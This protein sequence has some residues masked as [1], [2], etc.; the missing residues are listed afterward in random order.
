MWGARTTDRREVT[1]PA[2]GRTMQRYEAREYDK[3]GDRWERRGKVF[4]YFCRSC[5]DELSLQQ[6]TGLEELLTEINAGRLDRETFL[7][8]YWHAVKER[9]GTLEGS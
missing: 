8:R 6:R 7:Q 2:C 1:C 3:H 5:H 9:H 4:E